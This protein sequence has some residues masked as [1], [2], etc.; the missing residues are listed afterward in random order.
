MI[1]IH[2]LPLQIP[3]FLEYLLLGQDTLDPFL[4][5]FKFSLQFRLP[6]IYH[7]SFLYHLQWIP[8]NYL[9]FGGTIQG[10]HSR[11]TKLP[12]AVDLGLGMAFIIEGAT[13]PHVIVRDSVWLPLI[14]GSFWGTQSIKL[15]LKSLLKLYQ[16][17]SQYL[18]SLLCFQYICIY[19]ARPTIPL[20]CS[21]CIPLSVEVKL[22][23]VI[24][25]DQSHSFLVGICRWI[26]HRLWFEV[27]LRIII[28]IDNT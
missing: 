24:D 28:R 20:G 15:A 12:T 2:H 11:S 4:F 10:K 22:L 23:L 6:A 3:L 18:L 1:L 13:L 16:L 14:A 7:F 21:A 17:L 27:K 19:L 9:L 26:Y 5:L 25:W 8:I